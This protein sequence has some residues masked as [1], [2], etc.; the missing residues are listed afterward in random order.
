VSATVRLVSPATVRRPIFPLIATGADGPR[1]GFALR[2]FV[3]VVLIT[4]RAPGTNEWSRF[5]FLFRFLSV[6]LVHR[7][8]HSGNRIFACLPKILHKNPNEAAFNSPNCDPRPMRATLVLVRQTLT[9]LGFNRERIAVAGA[10]CGLWLVY[11]R[12]MASAM[13]ATKGSRICGDE[14]ET[15]DT[16]RRD[17]KAPWRSE[18]SRPIAPSPRPNARARRRLTARAHVTS[19][20]TITRPS[21]QL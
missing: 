13:P 16:N 18:R 14:Q 3:A 1:L 7:P 4:T 17:Q 9:A 12:N 10:A 15:D 11:T 20:S 19:Q 5:S 6:I 8:W 2:G 21:R